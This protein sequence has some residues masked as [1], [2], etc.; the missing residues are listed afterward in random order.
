MQ[1][2]GCSPEVVAAAAYD[3]SHRQAIEQGGVMTAQTSIATDLYHEARGGGPAVLLIPGASGDSGHFAKVGERLGDEFTVASYDRRGNSRSPR[4]PEG[5]PMSIADQADDAA[6][7]IEAFGIAPTLVFG[8][9]GGGNILLELIARRPEL[10]RA[11]VVHEPALIAVLGKPATENAE[12]AAI[13]ELASHDPR[14][15]METFVR[16]H[17]DDETF[18]SLNAEMRERMLANG[19]NLFSSELAAFVSYVPDVERIRSTG[20]R[21][22]LLASRDGLDEFSITCAWLGEQLGLPTD[23]VSG[24]HAPYLQHPEVFAEELRPI[25][26]QLSA[27]TPS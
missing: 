20:V 4:L 13:L 19:A 11:A 12:L 24:H 5:Q 7:L 3:P 25:L 23:Y 9:S 22:R 8:T 26:R 17:T 6:D 18:E 15:A 21:V 2:M 16:F 1:E 10:V 27:T 14:T